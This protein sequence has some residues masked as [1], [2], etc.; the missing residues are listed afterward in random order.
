MVKAL[1]PGHLELGI[2][3]YWIEGD[4]DVCVTKIAVRL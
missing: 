1:R 4:S 2:E 3:W